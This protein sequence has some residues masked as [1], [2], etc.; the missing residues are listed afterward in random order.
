MPP[1]TASIRTAAPPGDG[2]RAQGKPFT[3][4]QAAAFQWVNPKAWTMALTSVAIYAP[5]QSL[6]AV[7]FV[8]LKEVG[9]NTVRVAEAVKARMDELERRLPRGTRVILDQDESEEIKKQLTD[10]RYRAIVSA[11]VIFTVLLLFLAGAA[12]GGP[13]SEYLDQ[14]SLDE[15]KTA[16]EAGETY[17]MTVLGWRLYYGVRTLADPTAAVRWWKRAIA[18]GSM[19]TQEAIT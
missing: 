4:W 2:E 19:Q 8:V 13:R 16:A 12:F 10:L 9:A 6:L 7:A 11:F 5:S 14:R 18:A 15:L 3:F 1:E 17:A